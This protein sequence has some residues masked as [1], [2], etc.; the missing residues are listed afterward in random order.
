MLEEITVIMAVIVAML[1]LITEQH[2]VIRP[3]NFQQLALI[4]TVRM[5]GNQPIGIMMR[6]ISQFIVASTKASGIPVP[7]VIPLLI[8]IVFSTV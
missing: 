4:V 3:L 7:T 8:I 5:L 6:L 2:Q 1:P